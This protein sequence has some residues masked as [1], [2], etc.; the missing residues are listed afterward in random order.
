MRLLS[1]IAAIL[2]LTGPAWAQDEWAATATSHRGEGSE[3]TY[4]CPPGGTAH[5]I[6]GTDTYTDDSSVCTAAV[7]SGLITLASGGEVTIWLSQGAD[8]YAG[9]ARNGIESNSY[10]AWPHGFRFPGKSDPAPE[11]AATAWDATMRVHRGGDEMRLQ[12]TCPAGGTAHTIW[13]TDVYTDDSSVCTAAVHAGVI[14]LEHGGTFTAI[15]A[16][17]ESEYAAST[18]HGVASQRYSA[19]G[20]SFRIER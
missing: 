19:W 9:S 16:P 5:T 15:V 11:A 2:L 20:G 7:H 1:P 4:I 17:G 8:A 18:R 10:G 6:W 12:V 13:G 3:A 14:S